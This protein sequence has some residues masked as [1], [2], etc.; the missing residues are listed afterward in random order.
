MVLYYPAPEKELSV[1]SIRDAIEVACKTTN[2]R[3]TGKT[4]RLRIGSEDDV[5]AVLSLMT[6][7]ITEEDAVRDFDRYQLIVL[8]EI[9]GEIVGFA[10]TYWAYSTWSGRH[11]YLNYLSAPDE[12]TETSFVYTLAD[13]SVSLLG[14]RVV[15]QVRLFWGF[16]VIVM[17]TF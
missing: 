10:V 9:G 6:E 2:E 15:W 8:E 13:I 11:L 12:A 3:L 4:T 5:P 17:L 1:D 16:E 14:Q 7:H